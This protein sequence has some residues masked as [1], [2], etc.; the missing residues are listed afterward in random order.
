M[1]IT[2]RKQQQTK[3]RRVARSRARLFGTA[4]R[5]RLSVHRSLKHVSAQLI[6]D[7]AGKTLVAASDSELDGK[8][9]NPQ[10]IAKALGKLIAQKAMKARITKV[11]FDR[12]GRRYHGRVASVA[13]GARAEGLQ[14]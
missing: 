9:K 6:D 7:Q 13:N 2:E 12:R 8:E 3:Q 4:E 14:F 10:A 11:V 5:P 1:T